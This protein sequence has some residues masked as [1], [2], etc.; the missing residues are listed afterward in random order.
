MQSARVSEY[1]PSGKFSFSGM[2][3]TLLGGIG[4][5]IVAGVI[6]YLFGL[7]IPF[8]IPLLFPF[9]MGIAVGTVTMKLGSKVGRCRNQV[10]A[11][12]VA[13]IA[14]MVAGSS[15]HIIDYAR[16]RFDTLN[17]IKAEEPQA[18]SRD[19]N[20]FIDQWLDSETGHSGFMGFMVLRSSSGSMEI[21]SYYVGIPIPTGSFRLTGSAL[22]IYW[23]IEFS[24]VTALAGFM[25]QSYS[26]EPYCEQCNAWRK[27]EVPVAGAVDRVAEAIEAFQRRD[28]VVAVRA[29]GMYREG[30]MARLEMEF[31]PVCYDNSHTTL[32]VVQDGGERVVWTDKLDANSVQKLVELAQ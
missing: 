18:S 25:N 11:V 12:S 4:V 29:L 32:A 10:L 28:I 5:A 22:I 23:F 27:Y 3:L 9:L 17:S 30:D 14:G 13:V 24:I 15:E 21:A 19:I 7:V 1:R 6:L 31:C 16:F 20:R 2:L 26:R 8:G